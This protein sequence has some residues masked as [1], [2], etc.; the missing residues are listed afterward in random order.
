MKRG[1]RAGRQLG[2]ALLSAQVDEQAPPRVCRVYIP[3]WSY[4]A[5]ECVVHSKRVRRN[6]GN[7]LQLNPVRT[8]PLFRGHAT[9]NSVGHLF[10]RS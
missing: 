5:H 3:S 8:A 6:L 7:V 9:W 4:A 2:T 10:R 1:G